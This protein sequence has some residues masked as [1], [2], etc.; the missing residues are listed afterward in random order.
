MQGQDQSV[1]LRRQGHAGEGVQEILMVENVN[2]YELP[3]EWIWPSS[4]CILSGL[5]SVYGS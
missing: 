1:N 5:G 2:S 4:Y 3:S